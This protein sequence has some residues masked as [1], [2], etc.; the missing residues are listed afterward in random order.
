M[1]V[2][3]SSRLVLP[4]CFVVGNPLLILANLRTLLGCRAQK[5]N[6]LTEMSVGFSFC[7]LLCETKN[8]VK[9]LSFVFS[10]PRPFYLPPNILMHEK[11]FFPNIDLSLNLNDVFPI[12]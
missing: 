4:S 8:G 1:S 3:E 6:S 7:L 10:F 12:D 11:P 5:L 9:F 2:E